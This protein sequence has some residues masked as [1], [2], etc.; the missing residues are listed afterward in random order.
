M[1]SYAQEAVFLH[2]LVGDDSLLSILEPEDFELPSFRGVFRAAQ[3]LRSQGETVSLLALDHRLAGERWYQ[4]AGSIGF[5]ARLGALPYGGSTRQIA[6]I[7]REQRA[8]REAASFNPGTDAAAMPSAFVSKGHEISEM[9]LFDASPMKTLAEE[10]G[11]EAV[12]F[13][14][15]YKAMDAMLGGGIEQGAVFVIAARPSVGKTTLGVNIAAH[16]VTEGKSVLFLSLEMPR[17]KIAERALCAIYDT[18][19]AVARKQ[20]ATMLSTLPGEIVLED[21]KN[22]LQSIL[23]TISRYPEVDLI[24]IDYFQLISHHSRESKQFQLEEVSR[25]LKLA[26]MDAK[27][28][29]ILLAQLNREIEREKANREPELSDLRGTGALEQDADVVTFLWDELAKVKDNQFD[30]VVSDLSGIESKRLKWIVRKNRNG[31]CGT[32]ELVYNLPHFKLD[33]A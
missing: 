19:A 28:P 24:V 25:S 29:I 16:A 1:S 14:T 26:A 2:L 7:L 12:V 4:D 30:D 18:N 11:R 5:L 31:R 23:A 33:E 32:V 8:R 27:K 21:S 17:H 6:K 22:S 13:P 10:M 15:G 3:A 9:L 20:A